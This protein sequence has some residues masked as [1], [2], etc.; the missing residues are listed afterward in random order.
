MRKATCALL[1]L[2]V[3][4][5]A[6]TTGRSENTWDNS[7]RATSSVQASPAKITLTW[8]QDEQYSPSGY[9]VYRRLPGASSWGTGTALSGSTTSFTDTNVVPGTAYEYRIVK[10][11]L[12]PGYG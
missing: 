7:V 6:A 4:T 2:L 9:T 5:F 1:A 12:V 3:T 10:A 8:L 11:S